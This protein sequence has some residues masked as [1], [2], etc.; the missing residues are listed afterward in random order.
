MLLPYLL[1]R[2]GL[3]PA[4]LRARFPG[5]RTVRIFGSVR[6]PEQAGHDLTYQAQRGLVG[7]TVPRTITAD[8]LTSER[9]FSAALAVLRRPPGSV[10]DLGLV[11]SLDPLVASLR[12]GLTMPNG[13]LGGGGYRYGVY[14]TKTGHIAVAALEPHFEARLCEQLGIAP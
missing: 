14:A 11:E 1:A 5:I 10:M 4:S 8:V 13:T 12:H 6:D 3:D 9:A 7:Q 2:L